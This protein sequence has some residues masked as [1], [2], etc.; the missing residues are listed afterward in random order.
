M[1]PDDVSRRSYQVAR[2]RIPSSPGAFQRRVTQVGPTATTARFVIAAG[3]VVSGGVR[4][5]GLFETPDQ[6]GTS[7]DAVS[8][9]QY[10]VP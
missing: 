2:P 8:A 9:N 5:V 1:T 7:S 6:F 4:A 3:R 10:R